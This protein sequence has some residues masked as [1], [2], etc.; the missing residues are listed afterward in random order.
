MTFNERP[1]MRAIKHN[2][3]RGRSVTFGCK[4]RDS[5]AILLALEFGGVAVGDE[6]IILST[7]RHLDVVSNWWFVPARAFG[8]AMMEIAG[9]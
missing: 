5:A 1:K 6:E 4:R 8:I 3:S 2:S 9:L 7:L